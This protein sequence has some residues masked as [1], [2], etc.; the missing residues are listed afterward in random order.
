M[1]LVNRG[2]GLP[3]PVIFALFATGVAGA[4]V[5]LALKGET[6]GQDASE[7]YR[8]SGDFTADFS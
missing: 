1:P 5:L 4:G 2:P 6:F 3:F 7:K 8:A